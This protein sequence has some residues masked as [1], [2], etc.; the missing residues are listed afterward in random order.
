MRL[1]YLTIILFLLPSINYGQTRRVKSYFTNGALQVSGKYLKC[2]NYDDKH[3]C[4]N[5][6]CR[7]IGEWKYYY[8]NGN[9]E[10]V[11]NYKILKDCS[12]TATPDG[13]WKYYNNFG[14]LVKTEQ[15]KEGVLWHADISEISFGD[16]SV[17]EIRVREGIRDTLFYIVD[18]SD[19]LNLIEN[20]DFSY[21]Y[22]KPELLIANGQNS[23]EDQL[24]FWITP[25]ENTPDYYNT[26]RK[27]RQ[28]PNN[29]KHEFNAKY[30]YVGII[31]YHQPTKDYSE[32]ITGRLKTRLI[33]GNDYCIRIR[34]RLSQNAG[35]SINSLGIQLSELVPSLPN[36]VLSQAEKAQLIMPIDHVNRA[37]WTTLC[38]KYKARGNENY[39]TIGRYQS[40]SELFIDDIQALNRSQGDLNQSAYY[41]IDEVALF[42]DSLKCNCKTIPD[43]PE[44]I[45]YN[46]LPP[47]D[48]AE[49]IPGT[50]YIL[51]NIFFDFDKAELLP[52][53]FAE[54]N[55]LFGLLC[56]NNYSITIMG[57]TDNIGTQQYNYNLSLRRA[58]AVSEWLIAKGIEPNRL[59]AE[60]YGANKAHTHNDS[61]EHRALN[62][63]VEVKIH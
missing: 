13:L 61:E 11:E 63:R 26:F 47:A 58:K 38:A 7:K 31:L 10:R 56:S 37:A 36:T 16:K 55:K 30:N 34:L 6:T 18:A 4:Y 50:T 14:D 51:S 48:T 60:G 49:I 29:H 19:S 9:I 54:L 46:T 2:A 3:P 20:G 25:N 43:T 40:I 52:S 24:P 57:H 21:Y 44:I 22:G 5:G 8:E 27:V 59:R 1:L 15:Y 41:L 53:S 35:F 12:K 17:G 45:E 62:R 28:I 32:Y 23:I 33:A 39:L 42:D